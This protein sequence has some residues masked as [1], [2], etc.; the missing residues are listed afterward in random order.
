MFTV[1]RWPKNNF[2]FKNF[3]LS[4]PKLLV[5]LYHMGLFRSKLFSCSTQLSMKF[6]LLI[7]VKMPIMVGI[8]TFVSRINTTC[9]LISKNTLDFSA[10]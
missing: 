7:N 6:I 2:M 8:L 5:P 9:E 4:G 3:A 10:F 1:N